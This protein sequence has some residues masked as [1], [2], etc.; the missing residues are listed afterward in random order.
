MAP[1]VI[2]GAA[3]YP[4]IARASADPEALRREVRAAFRP[5][6]WLAGLAGT[7]TYLF[8][9]TAIRAIYGAGGFAPAATILEVFAPGLF[10][11]FVDIL[12]GNV[13]YASG[14]GT[15][16]AVAKVASVAVGTG[17][18]VLLIPLFQARF[19]NGG[20]GV[21]VAFAL[22]E[23]VVFAGALM[24]LRRGTLQ[25]ATALDVARALG[26]AAATVVLFRWL[27]AVPP[28]VG[29]PLCVAAFGAVSLALGLARGRDLAVLRSLLRKG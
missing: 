2:L 28:W 27:P 17:L 18:N 7:G 1:A 20:I 15:G 4:H 6:L 22:S 19:G 16:F 26:T 14:R 13:I 5:L 29:I 10:L 9:G 24:V 8:A 25:A 21:V 3:A 12:L 23:L 11:L